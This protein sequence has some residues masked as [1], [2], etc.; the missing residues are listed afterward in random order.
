MDSPRPCI[1]RP[2]AGARVDLAAGNQ[3]ITSAVTDTNGRYSI[4][5]APGTYSV[6]VVIAQGATT[7]EDSRTVKVAPGQHVVADFQLSFLA[8]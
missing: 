8:A 5:V 4:S 6:H 7:T 1:F 3:A 2:M